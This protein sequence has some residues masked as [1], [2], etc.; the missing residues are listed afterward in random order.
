MLMGLWTEP[1]CR[2]WGVCACAQGV[3]R[4]VGGS[5]A[6]R[7]GAAGP[8]LGLALPRCPVPA[9]NTTE[10][11]NLNSKTPSRLLGRFMSQDGRTGNIVVMVT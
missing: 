1:G 3:A 10:S 9:E 5:G 8:G 6:G 11:K 7:E 2:D 4:I